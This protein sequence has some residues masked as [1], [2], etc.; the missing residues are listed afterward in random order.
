MVSPSEASHVLF[1]QF[2]LVNFPGAIL[3]QKNDAK[4][5]TEPA[6]VAVEL[7]SS[8]IEKPFAGPADAGCDA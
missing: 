4:R 7:V 3:Y 8:A 6:P 1:P 5:R 2:A